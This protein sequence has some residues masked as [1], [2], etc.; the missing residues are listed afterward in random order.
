MRKTQWRTFNATADGVA[1][2][3]RAKYL[4]GGW[5][6]NG[7]IVANTVAR[8]MCFAIGGD[9]LTDS[10]LATSSPAAQNE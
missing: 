5:N 10:S 7:G 1:V 9:E 8:A 4:G 6:A 2:M 3:W